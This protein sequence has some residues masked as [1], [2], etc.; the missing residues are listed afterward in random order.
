MVGADRVDTDHEQILRPPPL[1]GRLPVGAAT[2]GQHREQQHKDQRQ[3]LSAGDGIGGFGPSP[4][5]SNE[6]F[7]GTLFGSVLFDRSRHSMAHCE[8][9]RGSPAKSDIDDLVGPRPSIRSGI[10]CALSELHDSI[11]FATQGD[12]AARETR[13]CLPWA[14]MLRPFQGDS[15]RMPDENHSSARHGNASTL[16]RVMGRQSLVETAA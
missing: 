16:R 9:P 13:G 1:R 8:V 6:T 12:A 4:S 10:C 14:D 3:P 7:N 11:R 2:A 15:I 5:R